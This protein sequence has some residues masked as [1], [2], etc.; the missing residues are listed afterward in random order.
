[1]TEPP[2][3]VALRQLQAEAQPPALSDEDLALRFAAQNASRLRYVHAWKRWFE[4][5]GSRWR[6]D[7]TRYAE[8]L[9][10]KLCR[11]A[12]T[13]DV[14]IASRAKVMA[15]ADLAQTDRRLALS[16]ESWDSDDTALNLGDE[17]DNDQPA[18]R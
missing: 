2:K 7:A 17:D 12:S 4:W 13:T 16:N 5:T 9:A 1:M 18:N 6:Y 10:R 3:L 15:I 11:K 14:K 8:D